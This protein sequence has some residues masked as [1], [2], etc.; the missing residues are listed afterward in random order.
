M[1]FWGAGSFG[2]LGGLAASLLAVSAAITKARFRWPW[3][4]QPDGVWP[5]LT[6]Y[7][8][9]VV[10]G[11]IV[12]ACGYSTMKSGWPAFLMGIAAPS[13]V[14]NAVGLIEVSERR[15]EAPAAEAA[16]AALAAAEGGDDGTPA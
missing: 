14:Q 10:L 9:G 6:V 7:A 2:L 12:S 16:L 8:I 3:R 13:V 5:R 15:A 11:G 4:G 1:T